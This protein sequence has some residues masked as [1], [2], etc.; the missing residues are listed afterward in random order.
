[1]FRQVHGC[2]DGEDPRQYEWALHAAGEAIAKKGNA[3][4]AAHGMA[5]RPDQVFDHRVTTQL[6]PVRDRITLD[7]AQTLHDFFYKIP[8]KMMHTTIPTVFPWLFYHGVGKMLQVHDGFVSHL[9]LVNNF[10]CL[11]Q[12][13][14]VSFPAVPI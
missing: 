1:M 2:G 13:N 14:G 11:A 12:A 4:G 10:P 6:T 3:P 5:Q 7:P 8:I 9:I